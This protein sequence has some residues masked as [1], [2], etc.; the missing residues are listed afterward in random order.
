MRMSLTVSNCATWR[1]VIAWHRVTIKASI[2]RLK[3]LVGR[4]QGTGT[5][6]VLP[7]TPQQTRGTLARM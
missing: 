4:A 6:V 3:P 2:K 5:W 1:T 7:Q